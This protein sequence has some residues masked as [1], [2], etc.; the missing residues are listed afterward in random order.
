MK[1]VAPSRYP[2]AIL[3]DCDGTVLES[4]EIKVEAFVRL[5]PQDPQR[6]KEVRRYYQENSGLPRHEKLQHVF[7]QLYEQ[8]LSAEDEAAFSR[9]YGEAIAEA[10]GVCPL[11]PGAR[12]LLE[13]YA[14]LCPLFL[15]SGTPDDELHVAVEAHGLTRFF[16]G[17]FG[18]PTDKAALCADIFL[19]WR[20][21]PA[22]AVMVGDSY[23][24]LEAARSNGIPFIGRLRP[25]G[26]TFQ[27]L[28][29]PTAEDL[30]GVQ[31]LLARGLNATTPDA[32]SRD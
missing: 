1:D 2:D 17:I 23:P 29:V 26:V 5:L 4:E 24:D 3:L 11:V 16:A 12:E 14:P 30:W 8:P 21:E 6:L 19:R 31:A 15:V 27:G 22:R 13:K 7:G 18:S 9:R 32:G 20:L 25:E 28:G 10:Y